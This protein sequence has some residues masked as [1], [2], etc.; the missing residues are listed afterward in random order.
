MLSPN[1]LSTLIAVSPSIIQGISLHREDQSTLIH[2]G[3]ELHFER[4]FDRNSASKTN[5]FA[6]SKISRS[7]FLKLQ[8]DRQNFAC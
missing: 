4:H 2:M 3:H 8:R 1:Q 6:E 7:F 5:F